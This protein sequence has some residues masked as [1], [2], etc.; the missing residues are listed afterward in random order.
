MTHQSPTTSAPQSQVE[1]LRNTSSDFVSHYLRSALVMVTQPTAADLD[2]ANKRLPRPK[3]P[4]TASNEQPDSEMI[5]LDSIAVTTESREI[6]AEG[7]QQHEYLP[8]PFAPTSAGS[9]RSTGNSCRATFASSARVAVASSAGDPTYAISSIW[10]TAFGGTPTA[11][12][13]VTAT[14]HR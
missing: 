2:L 9:I 12:V 6:L 13:G 11:A 1:R 8:C 7:S 3:A 5:R 10:A 4:S 14:E